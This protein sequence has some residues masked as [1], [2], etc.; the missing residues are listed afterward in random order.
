MRTLVLFV[1][2]L[3]CGAAGCGKSGTP[4]NSNIQTPNDQP[5]VSPAGVGGGKATPA[6][7][8]Q[9]LGGAGGQQ[10]GVAAPGKAGKPLPRLEIKQ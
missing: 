3:A 4:D 6:G 7:G 8:P 2:V 5:I 1:S 9:V 10:L